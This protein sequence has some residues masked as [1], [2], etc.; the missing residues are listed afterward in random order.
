[1]TPPSSS[2]QMKGAGRG[3]FLFARMKLRFEPHQADEQLAK[4]QAI[5]MRSRD[6]GAGA[7]AIVPR[8]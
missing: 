8:G 4:V 3:F 2:F 1:M 5:T 6:Q 7:R